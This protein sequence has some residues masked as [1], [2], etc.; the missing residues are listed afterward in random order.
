MTQYCAALTC[1]VLLR[2]KLLLRD[3]VLGCYLGL[4]EAT[5]LYDM[6]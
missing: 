6:T 4:G 3:K 2:D 1:R 5:V